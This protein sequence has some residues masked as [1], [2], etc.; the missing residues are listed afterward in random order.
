MRRRVA[1]LQAAAVFALL[2][3]GALTLGVALRLFLWA[4]GI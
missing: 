2:L 3:T 4:A 1:A